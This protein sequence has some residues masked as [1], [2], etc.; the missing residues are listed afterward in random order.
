MH[1]W[2]LITGN[3]ATRVCA[4]SAIG[5]LSMVAA[6]ATLKRYKESARAGVPKAMI[7][8]NR[9][10]GKQS[11]DSQ[12]AGIYC[13]NVYISQYILSAHKKFNMYVLHISYIFRLQI[14][15]ALACEL[16][17][18]GAYLPWKNPCR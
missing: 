1:Q 7:A 9:D 11:L 2:L 5:F 16:L 15:C 8:P 14:A 4:G 3:T 12:Q 6:L 10:I 13:E 17:E 18:H